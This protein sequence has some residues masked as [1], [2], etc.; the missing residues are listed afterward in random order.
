MAGFA[1]WIVCGGGAAGVF[2]RGP[3][4]GPAEAAIGLAGVGPVGG[5]TS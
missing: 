1:G 3:G 5:I 4:T 2:M